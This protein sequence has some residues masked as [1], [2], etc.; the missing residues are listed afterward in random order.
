MYCRQSHVT[1]NRCWKLRRLDLLVCCLVL[2]SQ[3]AAVHAED[4]APAPTAKTPASP[5]QITRWVADLDDNRF[6]TRENAQL[7]LE[8]AGAASMDEV[9]E[10]ARTGSLESSTRALNILLSWAESSDHEL[11]I[12][13]LEQIVKLAHRPTE[14]ELAGEI[15]ADAREEAAL[16]KIVELGGTHTDDPLL[17]AIV[18]NVGGRPVRSVQVTIGSHWKGGVEGLKLL[19]EVRRVST[20]SLHSAPLGDEVVPALIELPQL[21][22]IELYG[23]KQISDD[24]IKTL[25][26]KLPPFPQM[27]LAVRSGAQLGIQGSRTGAAQVEGVVEGSAAQKAGLKPGD[28]ITEL[29][30]KKIEDFTALTDLIA[31][32]EPGD[33]VVLKVT[34]LDPA[35]N[36]TGQIEVQV[37][38]DKWG[39]K[40]K[41]PKIVQQVGRPIQRQLV[42]RNTIH[43]D[44]R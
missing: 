38:F 39:E 4:P 33:S 1:D 19:N 31:K 15:L 14:A 11:R 22:R 37:T 28:V 8:A 3:A 6:D 17:G 13:A 16:A 18:L 9:A 44:R 20:L 36:R 34:R 12:A 30:D 26:E 24:A 7:Q 27:D 21:K 23:M 5:E 43:I 25:R 32:H 41:P 40:L 29:D 35:R 10:V 2:V 42:P